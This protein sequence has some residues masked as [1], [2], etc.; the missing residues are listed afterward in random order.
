M[1]PENNL[2]KKN[3][4]TRVRLL[5]KQIFPSIKLPPVLLNNN[6]LITVDPC[7]NCRQL[8]FGNPL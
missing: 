5:I 1:P 3:R 8:V 7:Q 6:W 2:L 4:R